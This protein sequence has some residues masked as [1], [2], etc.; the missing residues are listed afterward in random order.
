MPIHLMEMKT[1]EGKI[2]FSG[3]FSAYWWDIPARLNS[4]LNHS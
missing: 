1:A 3:F 4:S 2:F